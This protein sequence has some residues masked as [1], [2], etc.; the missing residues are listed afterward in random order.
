M[1]KWLSDT[2]DRLCGRIEKD[3]LRP[4]AS[5]PS[6][7]RETAIGYLYKAAKRECPRRELTHLRANIARLER[8]G[9]RAA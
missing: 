9:K 2:Y 8:L 3:T 5:N 6:R 1:L 4:L 7:R